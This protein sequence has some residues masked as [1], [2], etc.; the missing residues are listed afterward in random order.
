MPLKLYKRPSGLYHIRGTFKGIR[1][2][3]S[4]GTRSRDIAEDERLAIESRISK[5][6]IH[7]RAAVVGFGEAAIDYMEETGQ[8]RFLAP[9]ITYFKDTP[10][11]KIGRE[12]IERAAR[13][14]YP[15][16]AP[17]TRRRQA[18]TPA[19][20][21]ISHARGT[22]PQ[23][24]PKEVTRTRWLTVEEA[25][26]L[27]LHAGRLA[28]LLTF[29]LNTG[30]RTS[31]A[32]AVDWS[33][34]DLDACRAWVG[35]AK[36]D[37]HGHWAHFGRRTR[38]ALAALPHREGAVFLTPKGKPYRLPKG[39]SG[40]NPIKRGFN[41]AK[42]KAGMGDDVTPHILRHTWATW[43]YAVNPDPYRI[44]E[45]GGW[46]TG[47]MPRRYVKLAPPGYGRKVI[48]AGWEL[49]GLEQPENESPQYLPSSSQTSRNVP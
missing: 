9:L 1:V 45:H 17:A 47:E 23:P 34:V 11:A 18:I 3:Q 13:Q 38:A 10:I 21:V 6:S 28:P 27:I 29:F 16:V 14:L 49:F 4:A 26:A 7:G 46:A 36:M 8:R 42:A 44:G 5:E 32:L 24:R 15:K 20:A 35:P 22:R 43:A 2:D 37:T 31:Q 25:D 12:D 30:V 39:E 48:E 41:Q 40:G 19:R 33:D